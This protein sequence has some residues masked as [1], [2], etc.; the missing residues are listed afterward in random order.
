MGIVYRVYHRIWGEDLA[1]KRPRQGAFQTDAQKRTFERECKTWIDLGLHPNV[2]PCHYVRTI[3]EV[4]CIC[5]EY[6]HGGTL[7][8][9]I[10]SRRLYDGGPDL[11]LERILDVGIQM[12]RGLQFAHDHEIVHQDVKPANVL[13]APNGDARITDFGIARARAVAGE[14]TPVPDS[15]RSLLVSSGGLTPAYCS[16]EQASRQ[17]LSIKTDIWSW[18]VSV[19]EMFAGGVSWLKGQAAKEALNDLVSRGPSDRRIPSLP[20]SVAELLRS[21]F[22][23]AP[24]SR[25][26]N[27]LQIAEALTA[28]FEQL[29]GRR[30]PREAPSKL[31]PLPDIKN[32]IA[33][34]QLD[35]G[36]EGEAFERWREALV[37]NA[38]HPESI[39]NS[40]IIK[41]RKG[42]LLDEDVAHALHLVTNRL[43]DN[44]LSHYTVALFEK[45]RGND[46]G[47]RAALEAA[48][49]CAPE[50][51]A[52][53]QSVED[54]NRARPGW[55]RLIG[56]FTGHTGEITAFCIAAD[57]RYLLSGSRDGTTR[58]WEVA[59][60]ACLHVLAGHTDP[61]VALALSES[62]EI[63]ITGSGGDWNWRTDDNSVRIWDLSDGQCIHVLNGHT[64][65]IKTIAINRDTTIVLT[66]S[67]D[68]TL[69][70]WD[71]RTGQLLHTLAGHTSGVVGARLSRDGSVAVSNSD[72]ETIRV[73]DTNT[74]RC[75][76]VFDKS[77]ESPLYVSA[78]GERLLP[79]DGHVALTASDADADRAL[80]PLPSGWTSAQLLGEGGR[81]AFS[82][83]FDRVRIWDLVPRR[84]CLSTFPTGTVLSTREVRGH[85]LA[86][87]VSDS[88]DAILL[89]QLPDPS[90]AHQSPLLLSR[91]RRS[92]DI[93]AVERAFRASIAAS[94]QEEVLGNYLGAAEALE[95]ARSLP[96]FERSAIVRT[97]RARLGLKGRRTGLRSS[98]PVAV[99]TG[100]SDATRAIQFARDCSFAVSSGW[101]GLI[102]VWDIKNGAC[103]RTCGNTQGQ[104]DILEWFEALAL[105][106]DKKTCLA[107]KFCGPIEVWDLTSGGRILCLEGHTSRVSSVT[108][109][110]DCRFAVSGSE[111]KS[112]RIW[113]VNTG[114]CLRT[115]TFGAPVTGVC[116]SEDDQFLLVSSG[117]VRL[118]ELN[119]GKQWQIFGGWSGLLTKDAQLVLSV[120]PVGT[121]VW[122]VRTANKLRTLGNLP[123]REQSAQLD[124][125]CVT[126]DSRFVAIARSEAQKVQIWDLLSG[127]QIAE[128]EG[129]SPVSFSPDSRFILCG[130]PGRDRDLKVWEL[131]WDWAFS[132]PADWDDGARPFLEFF[133]TRHTPYVRGQPNQDGF[134]RAGVPTWTEEDF[135][136][137][138]RDLELRGYGW[139]RPEGIRRRLEQLRKDPLVD[140]QP[141]RSGGTFWRDLLGD[142]PAGQSGLQKATKHD[143][144]STTQRRREPCDA[145][146]LFDSNAI[147]EEV[148]A[149]YGS[150][151]QSEILKALGAA[152]GPDGGW[153]AAL[154]WGC[155]GDLFEPQILAS[156]LDHGTYNI[157]ASLVQDS[158]LC[159]LRSGQRLNTILYVVGLEPLE[160]RHVAEIHRRLQDPQT[161]GYLGVFL[162]RPELLSRIAEELG[163]PAKMV[164]RDSECTGWLA[165]QES[166]RQAGLYAGKLKFPGS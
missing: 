47:A 45:E 74:G 94:E 88:R 96:G 125:M 137:L 77:S 23:P 62:N 130:A 132:D 146:F 144:G 78:D 141:G 100:I 154:I 148:S 127:H 108:L 113:D 81:F 66:G 106:L 21:C 65:P 112:V 22:N 135:A 164:I 11:A 119:T 101:D 13:L 95:R 120:E 90:C 131:D 156:W 80:A 138:V 129:S 82:E 122:D 89:W 128:I 163:V 143:T 166:M 140:G 60:G 1:L 84:R 104:R 103:L 6:V 14:Y 157:D 20:R 72:D 85:V 15:R 145:I 155:D 133:L 5:A 9:S 49:R 28:E 149:G 40:N 46:V 43:P 93:L 117:G 67:G 152:R 153:A 116:L 150:Y 91:V 162:L 63:A 165:S 107:A 44:W 161:A 86:A 61:V 41:W 105:S 123:N 75:L 59:S 42:Q 4:P 158:I 115:E 151:A 70:L 37:I 10:A 98:Y 36:D 34:S 159:T 114:T 99:L 92:S 57:G 35:L 110:A 111:D 26:A 71:V 53:Q 39:Y 118:L 51:A 126:A 139:L 18:A 160:R 8:E 109:S 31:S 17:P 30:Y 38:C 68:H 24:E 69:R 142:A 102:R 19:M 29:T 55:G 27:M 134:H 54:L 25:P 76:K 32:N 58:F 7:S 83:S 12:A 2:V 50:E 73:W 147:S 87:A 52:I 64:E 136:G 3:D 56:T 33:L 48:A 97:G 121:G 16:P 79:A 124:A